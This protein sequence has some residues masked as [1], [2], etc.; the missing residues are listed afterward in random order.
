ADFLGVGAYAR[1]V[2]ARVDADDGKPSRRKFAMQALECGHLRTAFDTPGGPEVEEDNLV[3]EQGRGNV[4]AIG[5]AAM[6]VGR[7]RVEGIG[8]QVKPLQQLGHL[9]SARIWRADNQQECR[10]RAGPFDPSDRC[11]GLLSHSRW[12]A[13]WNFRRASRDCVIS[14][15]RWSR[16]RAE[17]CRCRPRWSAACR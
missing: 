16:Y 6:E 1:R 4:T 2:L 9:G 13:V 5:S 7:R 14:C 3:L 8:G 11:R 10:E 15:R 12:G 17:K